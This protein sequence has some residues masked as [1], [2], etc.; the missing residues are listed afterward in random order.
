MLTFYKTLTGFMSWILKY[1]GDI[2]HYS[3]L[4]TVVIRGM[5]PGG[6]NRGLGGEH[7]KL[8]TTWT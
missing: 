5:V 7:R 6:R 4:E 8:K 2:K 3:C 1:V